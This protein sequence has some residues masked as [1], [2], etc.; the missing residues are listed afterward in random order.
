MAGFLMLASL[1]ATAAETCPELRTEPPRLTV[2]LKEGPVIHHNAVDQSELERL[3]RNAH[4]SNLGRNWRPAGLTTTT[5][6]SRL[7]IRTL[8]Q[9]IGRGL[10]CAV[11]ASV[12]VTIEHQ[13]F[14]VYVSRNFPVGTCRHNHVLAHEHEHVAIFQRTLKAYRPHIQ[15]RLEQSVAGLGVV[16]AASLDAATA[17]IRDQLKRDLDPL[18]KDLERAQDAA[19]AVLDTKENY[20][21]EQRR[22]LGP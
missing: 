4:A 19:N 16:V 15:K 6:R 7:E 2:T 14:H 21:L 3:A 10:T 11:A 9:G 12:E 20:E 17:R 13:A 8:G 5:T 18:M 22:C 1:P